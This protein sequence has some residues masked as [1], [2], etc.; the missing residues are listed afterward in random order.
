MDAADERTS[1]HRTAR[2][3]DVARRRDHQ[4]EPVRQNRRQ[5]VGGA[6]SHQRPRHG[7]RVLLGHVAAVAMDVQVDE[8]GRDDA[9]TGVQ[10]ACGPSGLELV[11]GPHVHDPAVG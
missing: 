11:A 3:P 6:L 8:A 5:E 7:R 2:Q 9:V 10:H 1:R 4:V